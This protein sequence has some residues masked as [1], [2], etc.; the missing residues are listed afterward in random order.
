VDLADIVDQGEQSPLYIHFLLRGA[1]IQDGGA[2]C[3]EPVEASV[4]KADCPFGALY[5]RGCMTAG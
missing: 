1:G 5:R 2:T 4:K 3:A